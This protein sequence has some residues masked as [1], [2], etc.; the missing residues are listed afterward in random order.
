MTSAPK[1]PK[2]RPLSKEAQDAR[3]PLPPESLVDA[4]HDAPETLQEWAERTA[5]TLDDERWKHATL[6][7]DPH[8]KVWRQ[9]DVKQARAL[10]AVL[11]RI[12]G[13][14]TALQAGRLA[15]VHGCEWDARMRP[16]RRAGLLV[17]KT[18][19][20]GPVAALTPLGRAVLARM[21]GR[22]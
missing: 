11:D 3:R 17:P 14:L 7:A 4:R 21:E 8:A 12:A 10:L 15:I 18:S 6:C 22:R 9:W 13:E 5:P 16:L 2:L 19:P 20:C 1:R